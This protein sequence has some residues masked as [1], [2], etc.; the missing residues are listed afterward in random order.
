[1][2][3][4]QQQSIV[5]QYLKKKGCS[6]KERL[7]KDG[8]VVFKAIGSES[9]AGYVFPSGTVYIFS[10]HKEPFERECTGFYAIAEQE[11]GVTGARAYVRMNAEERRSNPEAEVN[12]ELT[13]KQKLPMCLM[14]CSNAMSRGDADFLPTKQVFDW[15]KCPPPKW[16]ARRESVP[17]SVLKT[18]HTPCVLQGGEAK[19][20]GWLDIDYKSNQ[21]TIKTALIMDDMWARDERVFAQ[22]RS[23]SGTGWVVA[24]GVMSDTEHEYECAMQRAIED[25]ERDYPGLKIDRTCARYKQLRALSYDPA[26]RVKDKARYYKGVTMIPTSLTDQYEKN[27]KSMDRM[28]KQKHGFIGCMPTMLEELE[29][30]CNELEIEITEDRWTGHR[31]FKL[32]GEEKKDLNA[33]YLACLN[34]MKQRN[35]NAYKLKKTE[36]CDYLMTRIDEQD[37]VLNTV[38]CE[39]WDKSD[40][41]PDLKAALKLDDF[42]LHGFQLWMRQGAGLLYNRGE[43]TDIQR[44]F[45]L[46]L[47]S[48]QQHIGKSELVRKFACG[49]GSFTQKTMNTYNKDNMME[50]YSN[51]I[52]EYGELGTQFRRT[53]INTLKS[54]VTDVAVSYRRPYDRE[55]TIYPV[56]TS[57]IGTT[58]EKDLFV[59]PTGNRRYWVI[60][61]AWDRTCWDAINELNYK[62]LWL[63]ARWEFLHG[64]QYTMSLEDQIENERR[65]RDKHSNSKELYIIAD[66]LHQSRGGTMPIALSR[67]D[68]YI[69]DIRRLMIYI[70]D[71]WH[72]ANIKAVERELEFLGFDKRSSQ[73]GTKFVMSKESF[74]DLMDLIDESTG[75][76]ISEN[77]ACPFHI[78]R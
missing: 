32:K 10:E 31:C 13:D 27:S 23:M 30:V 7:S 76:D 53:D 71:H 78:V 39:P 52:Y 64:Y 61:C 9:Y 29:C 12:V 55:A 8:N 26:I 62:Q 72:D 18:K 21:D 17:T 74:G 1:M 70:R 28:A 57:V 34:L 63:Q 47:Y 24:I 36:I 6:V 54:F 16:F 77:S 75:D 41:W 66:A 3:L 50:L 68:D 56:R 69:I 51:W 43:Q 48:K 15:I 65:C 4:T 46:I 73:I 20:L 60:D 14:Q 67:G 59:D 58:N 5:A 2:E 45:M 37:D 19:T 25:F 11:L 33:L 35:D 38:F 42:G 40:R 22:F 49:T 44:N